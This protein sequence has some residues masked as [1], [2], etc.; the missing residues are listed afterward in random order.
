MNTSVIGRLL[1]EI[2]WEGRRSRMYRQ[3]GRGIENVL[4]AQ[5]LQALDLLPRTAFLGRIIRDA[6][7]ADAA[8]AQVAGEVEDLT[9]AFLPE[10][11]TLSAG[12][13]RVQ[14]DALLTGPNTLVLVEAKASGRSPFQPAQ[15]SREYLALLQQAGDRMPLMLLM[16]GAPPPVMVSG[17]GLL[18]PLAALAAELRA[19][20][21]G[22]PAMDELLQRAPGILAWTTWPDIA[23]A[24]ADEMAHLE[25]PDP[26]LAAAV[27]RT[28]QSLV[29]AVSWHGSR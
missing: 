9:V 28:A 5:V 8:R 29:D 15:L 27:R 18:D 17:S 16:L 6:H 11:T 25:I 2:S 4:S 13:A 20:A 12:G 26:S 21:T 19:H 14:A 23:T 24:V 7:G 3:G 10:E 22:T 1:E